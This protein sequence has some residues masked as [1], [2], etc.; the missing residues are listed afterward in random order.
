MSYIPN[1]G[2]PQVAPEPDATDPPGRCAMY[3]QEEALDLTHDGRRQTVV[4]S[5]TI[6]MLEGGFTDTELNNWTIDIDTGTPTTV[7]AMI[8][9]VNIPV[10]T[11]GQVTQHFPTGLTMLTRPQ[12]LACLIAIPEA[13]DGNIERANFIMANRQ[14]RD[15]EGQ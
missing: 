11:W 2:Q 15:A 9:V 12:Y 3:V 7:D 6:W 1:R 4:L 13:L 5:K 8:R 10:T 14:R